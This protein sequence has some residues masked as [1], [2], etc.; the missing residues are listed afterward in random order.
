VF[1]LWPL[2]FSFLP[3]SAAA[4]F[5]D[6][7]LRIPVLTGLVLWATR[8]GGGL[9][10]TLLVE[11]HCKEIGMVFFF[12]TK[13]AGIVQKGNKFERRKV[14]SENRRTS[15]RQTP[16][17]KVSK[18]MTDKEKNE[19]TI[20]KKLMGTTKRERKQT[21]RKINWRARGRRVDRVVVE[22]TRLHPL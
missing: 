11:A 21:E 13:V 6:D 16:M 7:N 12:Q 17:R 15:K 4:P 3:G 19:S 18:K 22:R 5:V 2:G 9:P 1:E 10:S 14:V 20:M 8:A